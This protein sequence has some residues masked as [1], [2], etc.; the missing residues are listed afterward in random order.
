MKKTKTGIRKRVRKTRRR[1]GIQTME[2]GCLGKGLD[3]IISSSSFFFVVF[4]FSLLFLFFLGFFFSVVYI[5]LTVLWKLSDKVKKK[6]KLKKSN[7]KRDAGPGLLG[8]AEW[9]SEVSS[10]ACSSSVAGS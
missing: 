1:L 9:K 7:Y 3:M 10:F 6:R 8:Y 5:K 2:K 4:V